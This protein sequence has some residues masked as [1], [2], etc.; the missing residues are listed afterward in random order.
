PCV[1]KGERTWGAGGWHVDV[2]LLETRR[3][4]TPVLGR[5]DHDHGLPR[6]EA[7]AQKVRHDRREVAVVIVELHRMLVLAVFEVQDA[8][9]R[10]KLLLRGTASG[11]GR[12]E[13]HGGRLALLN[14]RVVDVLQIPVR[15]QTQPRSS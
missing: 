11:W 9:R 10:S 13:G 6:R 4:R 1:E 2:L 7:M 14:E 5:R 15:C 3:E 8:A 12:R